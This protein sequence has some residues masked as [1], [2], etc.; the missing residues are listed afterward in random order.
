MIDPTDVTKYDRTEEELQEF[1]LFCI[2]VAG[3]TAVVQARLLEAFFQANNLSDQT[4]FRMLAKLDLNGGLLQAIM[5]S[6]LGQYN[7]LEKAFRASIPLDLKTVTTSDLEAI[8]GVGAKTARYFLLHSRPNQRIA[9]LDTHMM[10]HLRSLGLTTMKT[11]PP[12]GPKY[13][14]LEEAFI[15][16]ADKANMSVADYDLMLWNLYARK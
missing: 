11:T 8:P 14:E 12:A 16:L 3:K 6:R 4:P 7:R 13:Q 5:D 9:A 2:I 15:D 1:W 10:K